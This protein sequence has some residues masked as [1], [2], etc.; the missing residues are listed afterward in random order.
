MSA[1]RAFRWSVTAVCVLPALAFMTLASWTLASERGT[2]VGQAD[3]ALVFGSAAYGY[4]VPGPA[5]LR[6]VS[7]AVRLYH[8]GAV[9]RLIL[10]GGK[11]DQ[12]DQSEA[13]VMQRYAMRQSVP[14]GDMRTEERATSTWQNLR[15]AKPLLQDCTSVLGISDGYHLGRIRLFAFMQG[16]GSL[17]TYPA[18]T[19]P[20][21]A[22][23]LQSFVRELAA[24]VY[25]MVLVPFVGD[26]QATE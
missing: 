11:V 8:E 26:P 7:T 23:H 17:D 16:W 6:R 22:H 4:D 1:W 3:C 25:Y 2:G 24:A 10:T 21:R 19:L 5:M 20:P 9:S 18:D 12:D 13:E 14:A 15:F